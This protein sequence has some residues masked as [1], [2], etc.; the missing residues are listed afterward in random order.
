MS[1]IHVRT[2]QNVYLDL[3]GGTADALPT[4]SV[5]NA[6]GVTRSLNPVQDAPVGD[7]SDRYH[8]VL[9]MADT[10]TETELEVRWDFTMDGVP[11][12][13][14][15][16]F[17]VVTPYLSIAEV[18]RIAPEFSDEDA[19]EVE[20]SVR[21]VINAH[22]GQSFGFQRG[23]TYTVEGHG[24]SALR[25]PQRL[26]GITGVN[27]L[28]SGLDV[29]SFIIT[30]GGWYLKKGWANATPRTA[31]SDS[32][33]WAEGADN[34]VFNNT[35]YADSDDSVNPGYEE[36]PVRPHGSVQVLSDPTITPVATR[37]ASESPYHEGGITVAPGASGKATEWKQ[38][39]PF[40]I[41]GDWGYKTVPAP[42]KEA[43]R[44]LVNDY[45][46]S[47][48]AYR[49]RYLESIKA[50]DWRLQFSSRAWESTGNA[51][52]DMLLSEFVMLDWAVI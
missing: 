4:V 51:R 49:D 21:H 19:A 16:Y 18:K 22:T 50:A 20:A 34:T 14:S 8:V 45:A 6:N 35:I 46:C 40:E 38:D 31:P 44:L 48:S 32:N 52:A 3:Y 39:Y 23:R 30:S 29:R 27:T 26:V 36:I 7:I 28:T 33:F 10:Q 11:V 37:R 24:E 41:T 25:L 12:T 1:E 15:D 17:E 47:E 2:N 42:V 13:K 9:N 43:A 5:T